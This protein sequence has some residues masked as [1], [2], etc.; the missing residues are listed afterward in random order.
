[1][2]YVIENYDASG[3]RIDD[4]E[5]VKLPPDM[6]QLIINILLSNQKGDEVS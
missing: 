3:R 4:L 5:K 2:G 6:E 1:M